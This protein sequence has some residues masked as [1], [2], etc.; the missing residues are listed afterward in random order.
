MTNNKTNSHTPGPWRVGDAGQTIFGPLSSNP[1]PVTIAQLPAQTPR[2]GQ[3]ERRANA[4]LISAAPDLLE[5]LQMAVNTV[6]CDSL[7]K[8]GERLPWY[9]AARLALAKV[10]A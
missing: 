10:N 7:D 1:S 4:R 8:S 5:A 2:C 9:K 3:D 6:E